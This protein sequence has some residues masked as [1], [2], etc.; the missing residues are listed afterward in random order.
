MVLNATK[1]LH[2]SNALDTGKGGDLLTLSS[3][4][5]IVFLKN[6]GLSMITNVS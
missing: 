1:S 6:S 3:A 2:N 4:A 5:Q